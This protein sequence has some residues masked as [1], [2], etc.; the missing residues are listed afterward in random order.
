M[1]NRYEVY[2]DE[3][4]SD[5]NDDVFEDKS[6]NDTPIEEDDENE[7]SNAPDSGPEEIV[8]NSKK[9]PV[10]GRKSLVQ[11]IKTVRKH[12]DEQRA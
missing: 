4:E 5:Q 11:K 6:G 7:G 8:E 3:S 9:P 12:Y 1:Q 10:K 2:N